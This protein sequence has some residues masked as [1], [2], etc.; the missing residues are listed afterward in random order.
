MDDTIVKC[1]INKF[2]NIMTAALEALRSGERQ[3]QRYLEKLTA[4]AWKLNLGNAK[5]NMEHD[6]Q[7]ERS[8]ESLLKTM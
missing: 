6:L 4:S 1:I 2:R 3:G 7:R 5:L 8:E